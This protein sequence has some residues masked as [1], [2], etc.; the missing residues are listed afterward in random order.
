MERAARRR[1]TVRLCDDTEE[2]SDGTNFY[3]TLCFVA[4]PRYDP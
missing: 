3:R 1:T 4:D 2:R